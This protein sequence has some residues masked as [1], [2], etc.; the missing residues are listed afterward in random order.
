MYK[1]YKVEF[2]VFHRDGSE[3]QMRKVSLKEGTDEEAIDSLIEMGY[4]RENDD[5][6]IINI[7]L[8]S[9]YPQNDKSNDNHLSKS[10]FFTIGDF[11]FES[12]IGSFIFWGILG[13][14]GFIVISNWNK[15]PSISNSERITEVEQKDERNSITRKDTYYIQKLPQWLLNTHWGVKERIE[16]SIEYIIEV[17]FKSNDKLDFYLGGLSPQTCNYTILEDANMIFFEYHGSMIELYYDNSRRK[18]QSKTGRY[19]D[20]IK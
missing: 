4:I 13:L 5:V 3:Y 19:F 16:F 12:K 17:K 7:A 6:V 14:I 2:R 11:I 18:L 15:E 10:L 20:R 9:D 1:E 8:S